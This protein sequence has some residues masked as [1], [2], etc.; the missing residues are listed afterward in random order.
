MFRL[1]YIIKKWKQT[2]FSFAYFTSLCKSELSV[3]SYSA[4]KLNSDSC[5]AMLC[6]KTTTSASTETMISNLSSS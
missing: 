3:V 4:E 1:D 2:F 5:D 6:I